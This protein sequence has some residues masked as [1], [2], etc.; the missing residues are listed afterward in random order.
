MTKHPSAFT[1][2]CCTGWTVIWEAQAHQGSVT[3]HEAHSVGS[4]G[5]RIR[6]ASHAKHKESNRIKSTASLLNAF[7]LRCTI[8]DDGLSIEGGQVLSKPLVSV[9]TFGDHR[10]QM[11]AVLLATETGG[12]VEGYDLHNIADP[13]FLNRLSSMPTEMLVERIQR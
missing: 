5:G 9:D 6:G 1:W 2:S 7:G 8:E 11:T 4:G 13:E 3:P 12:V 10:I